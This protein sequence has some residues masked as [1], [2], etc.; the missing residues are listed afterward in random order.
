MNDI[1]VL[2]Y[3]AVLADPSN[4]HG[5]DAHY[6]VSDRDFQGNR[7]YERLRRRLLK[8]AGDS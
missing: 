6:A 1:A 7:N 2:M 4:A 5:A 3:H 8:S